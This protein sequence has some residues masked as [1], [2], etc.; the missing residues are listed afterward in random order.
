MSE[1]EPESGPPRGPL[2]ALVL[3]VVL[4]LGCLWLFHEMH[5]AA[6]IQDCVMSGRTNC[7]PVR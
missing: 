1:D 3:V 5:G 7:A 4:V 2:A 6:A